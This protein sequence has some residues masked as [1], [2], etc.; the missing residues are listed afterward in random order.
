MRRYRVRQ[1]CADVRQWHTP[2]AIVTV[3][4]GAD[5]QAIVAAA[6][7]DISHW[8]LELVMRLGYLP[9]VTYSI[10]ELP[11]G[12]RRMGQV[13]LMRRGLPV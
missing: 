7:F 11:T 12:E 6:K 8:Q 13:R 9:R 5:T 3:P 1:H 2:S 10:T 4:D